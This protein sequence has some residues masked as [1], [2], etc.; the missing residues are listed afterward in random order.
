MFILDTL[1]EDFPTTYETKINEF[2]V[3]IMIGVGILIILFI[4]TLIALMKIFKK[5]N[6][7]GVAAYIPFYNLWVLLE[8][9]NKPKIYILLLLIP[10]IN[11]IFYF[12]VIVALG[13]AFRKP[14]LFILGM[15]LFP[16]IFIPFLGFGSSEYIGINSEAMLGKSIAKDLPVIEENNEDPINKPA[17]PLQER[18]KVEM[19]LGGG[20]YQKDYQKTLVNIE[21]KKKIQKPNLA[22]FRVEASQ[23]Q[24]LNT[25]SPNNGIDLL[26]DV[27]FIETTPQKAT[28]SRSSQESI[29]TTQ[30]API[31]TNN[32]ESPTFNMS[33][34]GIPAIQQEPNPLENS[35]ENSVQQINTP[36]INESSRPANDT[37]FQNPLNQNQGEINTIGSTITSATSSSLSNENIPVGN[38]E[39]ITSNMMQFGIP[40]IQQEPS[41]VENSIGNSTMSNS[42]N[43][44]MI[45]NETT[46]NP[47]TDFSSPQPIEAIKI[48]EKEIPAMS[49]PAADSNTAIPPFQSEIPPITNNIPTQ[50]INNLSGEQS[51]YITCPHCGAKIKNGSPKCFMCGKPL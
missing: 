44:S 49:F 42:T 35:T 7:S 51:E 34:I 32:Q 38:A 23:Q 6:R 28:D 29:A 45:D 22:G 18:K 16:L 43:P 40:I 17:Q 50:P 46:L 14:S 9:I 39:S 36:P 5:A 33:E 10:I 15:L 11:L 2:I 24:E 30:N 3:P 1:Y 41:P 8:I 13:K 20:V 25:K 47:L 26:A 19:S 21:V 4:I 31:V 12:Q 48:E 37:I 27:Q